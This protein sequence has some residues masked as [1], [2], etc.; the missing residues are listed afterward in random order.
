MDVDL[1]K[2][3]TELLADTNPG[4]VAWLAGTAA[5]T[6]L[7]VDLVKRALPKL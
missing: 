6:K 2:F 4:A 1:L 3:L 5:A 7:G